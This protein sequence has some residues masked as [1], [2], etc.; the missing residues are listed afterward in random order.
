[1]YLKAIEVFN[2]RKFYHSG[3]VKK[4]ILDDIYNNGVKFSFVSIEKDDRLSSKTTMVVGQN[5][6]GKTTLS[7][8][9]NIIS[10]N[11]K[12]N[13]YDINNIYM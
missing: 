9:L 13:H 5:N 12:L 10:K 11:L 2:F 3:D 4:D 7:Y 1:M 6:T 8:L